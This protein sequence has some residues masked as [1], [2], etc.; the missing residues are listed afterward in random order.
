MGEKLYR[1][2][3]INA[4]NQDCLSFTEMATKVKIY[5]DAYH[6]S[7]RTP[8]GAQIKCG[9]DV[10]KMRPKL[11]FVNLKAHKQFASETVERA[12][13]SFKR[14]KVRQISILESQIQHAKQALKTAEKVNIED[15]KAETEILLSP[16]SF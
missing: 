16:V 8:C 10:H 13:E 15:L 7:H 1:I 9:Y 6:I 3:S 5:V 14:R 2:E 4:L 11:K 12:L